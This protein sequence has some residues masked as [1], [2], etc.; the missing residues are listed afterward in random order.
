ML[1]HVGLTVSWLTAMNFFDAQKRKLEENIRFI[2]PVD[3]PILL[4]MDNINMY[5]GKRKHL[6]LFKSM[7]P[8]MWN[9]TAQ[10]VLIANVDGLEKELN[11]KKACCSPQQSATKLKP[12]ELFLEFYE[13]K[14]NL[15][16]AFVDLY[17]LEVL[18]IGLNGV[19][20]TL[21]EI[22]KMTGSQMNAHLLQSS[23]NV[24]RK[25]KYNI[26]I[27]KDENLLK[28]TANLKSD[29]HILP[30]SVEDNSTIFGTISIL[31]SLSTQFNLLSDTKNTEHIPFDCGNG[32]FDISSARSHFELIL[33]QRNHAETMKN[34]EM[35]MHSRD[36]SVEQETEIDLG[37]A[38]EFN[39]E[40][41]G[42]E[43]VTLENER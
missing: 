21:D 2:T 36:K 25:P 27:S 17:L 43:S 14:A 37:S 6:R 5:R 42:I 4:L 38:S 35:Q 12:N 40:D 23:E 9:F 22:K 13:E 33:S 34:R 8:T 16:S 3:V 39:E 10:A 24:E 31:N 28:P 15:F 41:T 1:N 11:D 32:N 29:V 19:N 26:E 18:D 20:M 30:L 7:G